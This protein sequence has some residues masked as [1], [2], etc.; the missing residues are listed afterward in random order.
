M[1]TPVMPNTTPGATNETTAP[2]RLCIKCHNFEHQSF[3]QTVCDNRKL[4]AHLPATCVA[5]RERKAITTNQPAQRNRQLLKRGL[6]VRESRR[7]LVLQ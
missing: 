6:D 3:A 2:L 7:Q 5:K 1:I 4:F